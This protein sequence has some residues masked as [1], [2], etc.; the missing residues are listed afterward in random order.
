MP[1][2]TVTYFNHQTG[3]GVITKDS[4]GGVFVHYD[5]VQNSGFTVL[6]EGQYLSFDIV[7]DGKGQKAIN[8]KS[9]QGKSS[10]YA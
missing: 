8:L 9:L 6:Y 7:E 10:A 1:T 2:G 4:G 5:A 3:F